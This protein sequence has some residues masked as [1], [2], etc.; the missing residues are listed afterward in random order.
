MEAIE[1]HRFTNHCGC[2]KLLTK[3]MVEIV[4]HG[5]SEFDYRMLRSQ[6][7]IRYGAQTK[8]RRCKVIQNISRV[9]TVELVEEPKI[10]AEGTI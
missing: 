8:C 3:S 10:K 9:A 6:V 2:G 5:L 4:N 7:I 1:K